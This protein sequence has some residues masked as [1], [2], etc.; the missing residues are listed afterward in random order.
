[1]QYT[2]N[3]FYIDIWVNH[4]L[5]NDKIA[6][7]SLSGTHFKSRVWYWIK[8]KVSITYSD[9]TINVKVRNEIVPTYIEASSRHRTK[10]ENFLEDINPHCGATGTHV[11]DFGYRLSCFSG[12][13]ILL[14]IDDGFLIFTSNA[15][16]TNLLEISMVAEPPWA[17][18]FVSIGKLQL[19]SSVQQRALQPFSANRALLKKF[20]KRPV[21]C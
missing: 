14:P 9:A 10:F 8:T 7:P 20:S 2:Y 16:P 1:M 11:L 12:L 3:N 18:Y 6:L 5:W 15:T 19:G 13:H 21:N 4:P 17:T